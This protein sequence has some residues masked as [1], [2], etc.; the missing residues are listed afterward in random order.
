MLRVFLSL[1]FVLFSWPSIC[2]VRNVFSFCFRWP[3]FCFLSFW[4]DTKRLL[5]LGLAGCELPWSLLQ[6]FQP[7]RKTDE[8]TRPS[9]VRARVKGDLQVPI[10]TIR[11]ST[12][13]TDNLQG[14]KSVP[15][16]RNAYCWSARETHAVCNEHFGFR[17]RVDPDWRSYLRIELR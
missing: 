12:G 15:W 11:Q 16:W 4:T 13:T 3:S 1:S 7:K 6:L 2:T 17:G 10:I 9:A 8:Q 14:A 5:A